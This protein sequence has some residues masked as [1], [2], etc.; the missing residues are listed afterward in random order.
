MQSP[1]GYDSVTPTS[2]PILQILTH[3]FVFSILIEYQS[4]TGYYDCDIEVDKT[5][6]LVCLFVLFV[7]C[8]FFSG[9]PDLGK[10]T[11]E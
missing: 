1:I 11:E 5:S 8:L 6:N 4:C 10:G 3:A 2:Q 9:T 7:V